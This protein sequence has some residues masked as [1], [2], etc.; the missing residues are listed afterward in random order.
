MAK[1][2]GYATVFKILLNGGHIVWKSPSA[3]GR[4]EYKVY[5]PGEGL[6]PDKCVGH[7]TENQFGDLSSVGLLAV[8][9][10]MSMDEYKNVYSV[11]RLAK[12][13]E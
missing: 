11:F 7:I 13:E 1:A 4:Q 10:K 6:N 9:G 8:E 2:M 3:Q 12:K 5:L